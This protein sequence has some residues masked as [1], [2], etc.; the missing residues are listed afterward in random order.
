MRQGTGKI[1]GK[2]TLEIGND[3]RVSFRAPTRN[4]E[5][6]GYFAPSYL[7]QLCFIMISIWSKKNT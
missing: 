5:V 6:V 2:Y 4:P 1:P 3:L 7:I